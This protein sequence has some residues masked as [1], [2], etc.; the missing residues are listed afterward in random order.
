MSKTYVGDTGTAIVLDCG[1][2]ISTASALTIEV[3]R[4]DASLVTWAATP[5]GSMALRYVTLADTLNMPGTW[6]VQALVT[7]QG[8]KW[9]GETVTLSVF[10]RFR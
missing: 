2:D 6:R 8:G 7:M 9:R 5:D 3:R 4:P 10:E 1:V